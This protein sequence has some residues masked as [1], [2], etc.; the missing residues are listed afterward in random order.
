MRDKL[1]I[2]QGANE[3]EY[4]RLYTDYPPRLLLWGLEARRRKIRN[5][6]RQYAR[7]RVGE[8]FASTLGRMRRGPPAHVRDKMTPEERRADR[9]VRCPSEGGY[10]AAVK[11]DM[12]RRLKEGEMW[13]M[14]DGREEDWERL[15]RLEEEVRKENMRRRS[16][17]VEGPS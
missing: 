4:D 6:T 7:E 2:I 12:G 8:V 10:T 5:K 13:Q 1:R 15:E 16:A 11:I 9:I 14:E 3:R 17:G